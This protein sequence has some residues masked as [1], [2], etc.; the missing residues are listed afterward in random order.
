MISCHTPQ[1]PA[2]HPRLAANPD[3][4]R[5]SFEC[6]EYYHCQEDELCCT[7]GCSQQCQKVKQRAH[8]RFAGLVFAIM[9]MCGW[10]L[11][12]GTTSVRK[13]G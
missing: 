13:S 2:L 6:Y 3:M 10:A 5:C 1:C 11:A 4:T 12:C 9:L 8:F 7:D